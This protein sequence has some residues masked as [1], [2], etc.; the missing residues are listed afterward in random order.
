MRHGHGDGD[1]SVHG[2]PIGAH[3]AIEQLSLGFGRLSRESRSPLWERADEYTSD[4]WYTPPD[5][6]EWAEHVLGGIDC[7]PAWSPRSHVR[8]RVLG[9]DGAVDDGLGHKLWPGNVFC[10][11]PYSNPRPWV[12]RCCV[13]RANRTLL[14]LKFDPSTKAWRSI[15]R[16][17]DAVVTFASR[18][19]FV[20]EGSGD[21][22]ANFP[23]AA[24][25]LG[26]LGQTPR[27]KFPSLLVQRLKSAPQ[28]GVVLQP[29][30]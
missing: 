29:P 25:Y 14:L 13:R 15:W 27:E 6:V 9:I 17:A 20:R 28:C 4:D 8:P 7:D 18:I 1:G 23:S 2:P 22:A 26:G 16:H 10:N 30:W 19:A 21:S 5:F 3:D 24:V 11:P 12:E